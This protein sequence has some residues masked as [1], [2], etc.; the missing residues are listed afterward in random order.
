MSS[1]P[2]ICTR[3]KL[4]RVVDMHSADS[5]MYSCP[6]SRAEPHPKSAKHKP[7][8]DLQ[9]CD[10]ELEFARWL[11]HTSGIRTSVRIRLICSPSGDCNASKACRPL[12]AKVTAKR[13]RRQSIKAK[14]V[15]VSDTHRNDTLVVTVSQQSFRHFECQLIVLNQQNVKRLGSY[16]V[17]LA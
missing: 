2:S 3:R 10:S 5:S 16:G 1:M 7:E 17:Y 11:A 6:N 8:Y 12:R 14:I 4:L 13:R 15:N 9:T